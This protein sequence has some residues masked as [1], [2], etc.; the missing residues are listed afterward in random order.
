MS[1]ATLQQRAGSPLNLDPGTTPPEGAKSIGVNFDFTL[2]AT[3]T[4]NTQV[5]ELG[6]SSVQT[7]YVDNRNNLS[8]ATFQVAGSNQFVTCPPQ[9][10]GFF[11][12]LLVGKASLTII[13]SSAGNILVQVQLIN[14]YIDPMIWNSGNPTV[15][16]TVTVNGTVTAQPLTGAF[17]NRSGAIAAAGV[18]Q[19]LAVA[20]GSRRRLFILNPSTIAGQ[21]IAATER[22]FIN[23][24]SAAGIDDGQ[25]VELQPGQSFDSGQ[26]PITTELITVTAATLGHRYIAKEI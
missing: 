1:N 11:P 25:S 8:S 3:A 23:F 7:L 13:G 6:M 20:N 26:G 15:S 24:T 18:S 21:N 14:V 4:L 9:T 10:Q 17:T 22:L 5:A 16:G 2:G 12:I 19:Q